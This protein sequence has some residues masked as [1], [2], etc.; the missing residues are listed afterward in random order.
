MSTLSVGTI[1]SNTT[2]PPA[3]Q[4]NSGTEIGT[5][6]RAWVNFDGSGTVGTNQTIRSS[7]NVSSVYKNASGKYTINFTNSMVDANYAILTSSQEPDG[8]STNKACGPISTALYLPSSVQVLCQ[9]SN[10]SNVDIAIVCVAI[11]R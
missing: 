8:S 7:F 3:I 5:F 9:S 4:N 6:C 1:K 11:F 2:L 10:G